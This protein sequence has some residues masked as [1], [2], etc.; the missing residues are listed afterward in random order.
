MK[1][2]KIIF[3]I[4]LLLTIIVGCEDYS[5][6]SA[7]VRG[8]ELVSQTPGAGTQVVAGFTFDCAGDGLVVW[9]GDNSSDYDKY[10]ELTTNPVTDTVVTKTYPL[11]ESFIDRAIWDNT[12]VT[13][14]TYATPGEYDVVV[15][16]STCGDFGT[17]IKQSILRKTI[18]VGQ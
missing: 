9:W 13:T 12:T 1:I 7:D 16:A 11:G 14:H 4:S 17:D 5:A 10:I 3:S 18:T 15:I 2:L 8:F 6:K